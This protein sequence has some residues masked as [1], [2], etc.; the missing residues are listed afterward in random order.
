MRP[1]NASV[2][3]RYG[4]LDELLRALEAPDLPPLPHGGCVRVHPAL[5]PAGD[6]GAVIVLRERVR[7]FGLLL[8]IT[9]A[10]APRAAELRHYARAPRRYALREPGPGRQ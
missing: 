2:L 4:S 9:P 7:A 6:A 8:V 1:R 5:L 3:A 10:D